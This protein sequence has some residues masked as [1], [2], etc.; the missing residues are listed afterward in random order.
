ME[1]FEAK[2]RI[3]EIN[4]LLMK[5]SEAYYNEDREIMS[6]FEYDALYDE[7]KK[8]E[9]EFGIKAENSLTENVGFVAAE[10][11]PKVRHEKPM[12]SLDKTKEKFILKEFL[13]DKTG[14]LSYKLDGLTIVLTYEGGLFSK[15]VTRG[16]GEV[17]E[18]IS[19]NIPAFTNVPLKIVYKGHL[20]VR[21]E[22]IITYSDFAK[23]N[24]EIGLGLEKYK[25]PRNLCSGSVRQLDPNITKKRNVKFFAFSLVEMGSD[26]K[27]KIEKEVNKTY[28]KQ[29]DF[30]MNM[31]FDVVYHKE[32]SEDNLFDTI[33]FYA[34]DVI[35]NDNPSDGLVLMFNDIE[36]GNSL[37]ATSKF[38]RNALAFKWKDE[39]A[40]TT[41]LSIEWSPSRTGLINP[42]AVFE[43]VELEGT[44]VSRASLH[45]ISIME[46]LKIGI[47]D[48]IKVF[49]ANMIIAQIEEDLTKSNNFKIPE[50]CPVCNEK[51]TIKNNDGVKTL[52]CENKECPVKNLKGFENFVSR[53]CMN[54]EGINIA[55]IET[56][57]GKGFLKEYADLYKLDRFKDEI[58]N[59]LGFGV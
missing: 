27:T 1:K 29:L 13:G 25:N 9:D 26:N 45:N 20:V 41:L 5:A 46:E 23:I 44:N 2:N 22:A 53:N 36:Y 33:D 34:K 35:K 11:L 21:G 28:I 39:T 49:K 19:N 12:L 4:D 59:L 31:G 8:L 15:G 56:F 40:E 16:N 17:G 37:G 10:F 58:I 43:P 42:V 51:L 38:P 14:V 52:F 48:K 3:N 55:T 24:E 18:D 30:L 47:G 32:V 54:I 57:I 7:L 50:V 6:N